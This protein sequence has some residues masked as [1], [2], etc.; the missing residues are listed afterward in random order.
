MAKTA[1]KWLMIAAMI[2]GFIASAQAQDTQKGKTESSNTPFGARWA[3]DNDV[4]QVEYLSVV[5]HVMDRMERETDRS[6][7]NSSR[8]PRI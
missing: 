1:F 3:Q 5:R 2:A 6:V 8:N 4:G 7:W